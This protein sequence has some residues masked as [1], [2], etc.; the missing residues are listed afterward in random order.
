MRT[1]RRTPPLPSS[2]RCRTG[3]RS[4]ERRPSARCCPAACLRSWRRRSRRAVRAGPRSRRRA[5]ST[6]RRTC[7]PT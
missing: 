2:R 1:A 5:P 7:S 4:A 3:W 6:R